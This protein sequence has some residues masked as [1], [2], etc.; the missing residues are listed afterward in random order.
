MNE[1]FN[2]E[3]E[4]RLS[5]EKSF[6]NEQ[7]AKQTTEKELNKEKAQEKE[8]QSQLDKKIKDHEVAK[9]ALK[10]IVNVSDEKSKH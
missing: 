7:E 9:F 6:K 5:L 10:E 8:I 3:K 1:Q 2:K 4:N